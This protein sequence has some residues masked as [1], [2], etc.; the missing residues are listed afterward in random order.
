MWHDI[1][2]RPS[3]QDA[4]I[5]NM[6]T[7]IPMYNTAKMELQK[8]IPNNPIS[9]DTNKDG[10]PRY[11]TYGTPFFNYGL[12]PQTWEDP[13]LLSSSGHGGDNDPLDVIELGSTPL[14]M[15][16]ITPCRVLGS[17]ELIDEGETDHK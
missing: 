14:L 15:G 11:Y 17:F 7:E 2:L 6:V 10:S 3:D 1:S 8:N 4:S 5:I 9:Q 13:N 12:I 16:S